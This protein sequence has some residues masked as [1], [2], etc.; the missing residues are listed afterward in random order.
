M[1]TLIPTDPTHTTSTS[2][3]INFSKVHLIGEQIFSFEQYKNLNEKIDLNFTENSDN[4]NSNTDQMIRSYLE[5]LPTYSEEV[6]WKFSLQCEAAN[7]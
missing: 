1:M 4:R 7:D 6:L 5:H 3:I 2:P